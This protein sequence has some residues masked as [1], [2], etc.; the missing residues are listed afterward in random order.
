MKHRWK[1]LPLKPRVRKAQLAA[2][3]V[4]VAAMAVAYPFGAIRVAFAGTVLYV[5]V[6]V[7]L[8]DWI[9]GDRNVQKESRTGL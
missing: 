3:P 1:K 7:L 8:A 4:G 5:A 2:V 9:G 6:F